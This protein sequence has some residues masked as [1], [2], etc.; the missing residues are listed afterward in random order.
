[1]K[2]PICKHGTL[3]PGKTTV[4]LERDGGV[5]LVYKDVPATVCDNCGERF[6]DEQTTSQLLVRAADSAKLGVQVEVR[7][8]AA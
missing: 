8:F 4:T 2:C 1:M 7:S 5:T 6:V 3:I